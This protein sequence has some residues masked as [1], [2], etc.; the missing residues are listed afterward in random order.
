M[1]YATFSWRIYI[2]TAVDQLEFIEKKL[3][4]E[5]C[6]SLSHKIKEKEIFVHQHRT[7]EGICKF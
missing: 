4:S 3:I 5:N 1:T 6:S 7:I 2:C